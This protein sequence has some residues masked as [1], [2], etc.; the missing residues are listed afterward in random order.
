MVVQLLPELNDL[1]NDV[2]LLACPSNLLSIAALS[3]VYGTVFKV[4]DFNSYVV[5]LG[6][7]LVTWN[8]MASAVIAAPNLFKL[9]AINI[10]NTNLHPIFY[11]LE[12]WAFQLQ[13]FVQSF[14]LVAMAL[15]IFQPSI[16][17][18][19]VTY[20][21]FPIINLILFIYWFPLLLCLAG[22]HFEDLFQLIPIV[23]QLMFLLSPILYSKEAL[24]TAGWTA[25]IN[26]LYQVLSSL[27]NAIVEGKV[28]VYQTII[29]L[30]LNIIGTILAGWILEKQRRKLPFLI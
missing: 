17:S 28:D 15:S 14:I 20:G 23:L 7:G 27:R 16:I 5:Y 11:S 9:N 26:P 2:K 19:L 12:E 6:I 4:N 25:D 8:A 24:G 3:I 1:Q 22:V 13:T 30:I 21:F 18:N 29:I 10:K